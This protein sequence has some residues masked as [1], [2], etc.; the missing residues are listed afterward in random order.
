M[1]ISGKIEFQGTLSSLDWLRFP[2]AVAVV[3]IHGFGNPPLCTSCVLE[4]PCAQDSVFA[5]FRVLFSR[6]FPSYAVPLFFVI[7]G[8]LFFYQ[9]T[10]WSW[11][12]YGRKL[13]R[14]TRR[15]LAP[16]LSW[17]LLYALHL[18]PKTLKGVLTGACPLSVLVARFQELGGWHIFW[19]SHVFGHT[20]SLLLTEVYSTGPLLAPFWFVRDLMVLVLF[21]P[22]IYQ[23][24]K[25]LG[26]ML[27]AVVAIC[28]IANVWIPISGFSSSSTLWFL[29]GA[30]FSVKEKD[31]LPVTVRFKWS[32]MV[33]AVLLLLPH[34][35]M[36]VDAPSD[37]IKRL[38]ATIYD[39]AAM[40]AVVGF[41][42]MRFRKGRAQERP[43]LSKS[44]FFI[45]ASHVF[46]LAP[47][48]RLV[49]RL[50]PEQPF[51]FHYFSYLIAPLATVV[52]CLLLYVGYSSLL[53]LLGLK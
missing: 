40:T 2:L 30:Y 17:I 37:F 42:E 3:F 26:G 10:G 39:L 1:S 16:Y 6:S 23:L 21:A 52:V 49:C 43:V 50:V 36:T 32:S 47:V 5:I 7:S 38:V 35:W 33:V 22:L 31:M 28:H 4:N 19:D 44:S 27:V 18:S 9:M 41:V 8:Y 51:V 14:R 29:L 46:V 12:D 48:M 20:H 25:R 45:Y 15:L 34:V 24:L 11:E 13:K 53:R